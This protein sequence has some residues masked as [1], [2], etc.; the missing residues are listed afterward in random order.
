MVSEFRYLGRWLQDDA[1]DDMASSDNLA[2]ATRQWGGL[3]HLLS[4]TRVPMRHKSRILGTVVGSTLL[5]GCET[6]APTSTQ[7][8]ALRRAQIRILRRI[9][10]RMP[11]MTQHGLRYPSNE[12]VL[13]EARSPLIDET[14]RGRRLNFVGQLIRSS[15]NLYARDVWSFLQTHS[16]SAANSKSWISTVN[17]DI[18]SRSVDWTEAYDEGSWRRKC[19]NVRSPPGLPIAPTSHRQRGV[20]RD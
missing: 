11:T 10:G 3:K 13:E 7:I 18:A 6:W 16:P 4:G 1:G 5:Y 2:R 17:A 19:V 20:T 9:T 14:I 15:A 12:S 8:G